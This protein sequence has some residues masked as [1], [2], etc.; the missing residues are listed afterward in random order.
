MLDTRWKNTRNKKSMQAWA[1][2]GLL[3]LVCMF[4]VELMKYPPNRASSAKQTNQNQ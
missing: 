2:H 1:K 3:V 4:I